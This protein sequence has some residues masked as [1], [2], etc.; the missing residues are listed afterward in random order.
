M[1]VAVHKTLGI[2]AKLGFAVRSLRSPSPT[3]RKFPVN[4]DLTRLDHF[5]DSGVIHSHQHVRGALRT[6]A[7]VLRF[8][9]AEFSRPEA[10]LS[11]G[12]PSL[13]HV[14]EALLMLLL[15]MGLPLT[16]MT[17]FLRRWG[18]LQ[19]TDIEV[20]KLTLLVQ[21]RINEKIPVAYLCKGCFQQN[22]KFFVDER[23]LIPRSHIGELLAPRS[24]FFLFGHSDH[25]SR[26]ERALLRAPYPCFSNV[27]TILDLCTGSGA[28]AILAYRAIVPRFAKDKRKL[29]IHATDI[30]PQALEVAKINLEM[31]NLSD[32]IQLY[33]GDL[34]KA[35]P[36]IETAVKNDSVGSW[37]R[38]DLILCNPPYVDYHA[39]DFLPS[40]Y[41]CEPS[42]ALRG[43][44][45][46]L[47]VIARILRGA[48][49]HLTEKGHIILECGAA[50]KI[51]RTAVGQAG[52]IFARTSNSREEVIILS[53]ESANSLS[54]KI[55]LLE[56]NMYSN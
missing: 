34:W 28:L 42:L 2:S 47:N 39:M 20:T 35:V 44:K 4:V 37:Q 13:D 5:I 54:E 10:R 19:L 25:G 21:R 7:N 33:C 11:F 9:I 16:T 14:E 56:L 31:K 29:L 43:G 49:M 18:S 17:S 48:P 22:E 26:L 50:G 41:R 15:H 32:K 30:N 24:R 6:V 52:G 3:G 46:G 38:Y 40:E 12:Q 8:A 27:S 55:K 23:V 1:I 51:L 53:R 45:Y 36:K